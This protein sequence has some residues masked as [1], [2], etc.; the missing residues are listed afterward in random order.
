MLQLYIN[1]QSFLV[2]FFKE[3]PRTEWKI[4]LSQVTFSVIIFISVFILMRI[5]YFYHVS[6]I[7]IQI[8]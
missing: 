4:Y 1:V 6:I 5:S 7:F 8:K 3:I 2:I